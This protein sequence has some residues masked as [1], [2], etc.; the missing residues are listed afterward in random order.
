MMKV[1]CNNIYLGECDGVL[2]I[3]PFRTLKGVLVIIGTEKVYNNVVIGTEK[4]Y[5][6][7]YLGQRRFI[8][9]CIWD[10]EGL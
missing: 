1:I 4:V 9:M 6:N 3:E 10:R 2:F 7:V 5:I 8:T